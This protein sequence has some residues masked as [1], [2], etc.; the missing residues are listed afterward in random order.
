MPVLVRRL[1]PLSHQSLCTTLLPPAEI[2]MPVNIYI[3]AYSPLR[4]Y[5]YKV[6]IIS[7]AKKYKKVQSKKY[8]Q[9]KTHTTHE[10]DK[11]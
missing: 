8:K 6:Q 11:Y 3:H 2:I 10:T 5:K 9:I 4:Q 1:G 7:T